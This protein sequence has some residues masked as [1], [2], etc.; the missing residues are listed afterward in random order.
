MLFVKMGYEELVNKYS[1]FDLR[2]DQMGNF[3]KYDKNP[4]FYL[5]SDQMGNFS[6]DQKN[7]NFYLRNDKNSSV[8]NK[9]LT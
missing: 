8:K 1:N 5:R 4:N 6:R 7:P 2:S 9:K 3:L